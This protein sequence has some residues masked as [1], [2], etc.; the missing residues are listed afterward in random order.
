LWHSESGIQ[1]EVLDEIIAGFAREC[2]DVTVE[3]I[4]VPADEL[5]NRLAAAS[6]PALSGGSS[7]VGAAGRETPPDIFLAP[8]DLIE[9]LSAERLL[10]PVT[11]W[12]S[13]PTLIPLLPEAVDALRYA[14]ALYGLPYTVDT[15]ALYYNA[16]LVRDVDELTDSGTLSDLFSAASPETPFALDTRFEGAFWGV[17]AFGR[18]ALEENAATDETGALQLEQTGLADWLAWLQDVRQRQG[19]IMSDDPA[20]LQELFAAGNA[21]YLVAGPSALGPLRSELETDDDLS[22]TVN[23]TPLPAGPDGD[24]SPFLRVNAFLFSAA[25]DEEQTRLALQFAEFAAATESQTRIIREANLVP[26]N[27]LA[28]LRVSDPDVDSFLAQAKLS[29]PLPPR[30]ESQLLFQEG[31]ELYKSV[32][33][34]GRDPARAVDEFINYVAEAAQPAVIAYAGDD[35]LACAGGRLRFWY[36]WPFAPESVAHGALATILNGFA[37]HCPDVDVETAYAS[38]DELTAAL[39]AGEG[40]DLFLGPHYLTVP[41]ARNELIQPISPLVEQPVVDAYLPRS[42][43]AV[44]FQGE[45]YGLPQTM[46]VEALYYNTE[47]VSNPASTLDEL[48]TGVGPDRRAVLD[49]TFAGTYWGVSA[50]G[51]KLFDASGQL[52]TE[53]AA[54]VDWLTWLRSA[55]DHPGIVLSADQQTRWE[56][57]AN[58]EAAYLIAGPAAL[59]PLRQQ[60]NSKVRVIPLPAGPQG[61]AGPLLRVDAFLFNAAMER[62]QLELAL[63]LAGYIS[64]QANQSLLRREANLVPTNRSA[65]ETTEDA[66]ITTFIRQ[67]AETSVLLPGVHEMQMLA[68]G[69]RIYDQMLAGELDP[70]SAVDQM[71]DVVLLEEDVTNAVPAVAPMAISV[72][73]G[74]RAGSS[75]RMRGYRRGEC[76]ECIEYTPS[77]E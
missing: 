3:A 8:H 59:A 2:P 1:A 30:P 12:V 10:K 61:P 73:A 57:F 31:D 50:F 29:V 56:L 6:Q 42:I 71:L 5:P 76:E 54:Y 28:S 70:A 44:S 43:Q 15:M 9:P 26:A 20:K 45:L 13:T 49:S 35:V 34:D 14:D 37:E 52:I 36:S 46:D 19:V 68:S 63:A 24:A 48:L 55:R 4:F 65:A 41:L 21:A 74:G 58:G 38:P 23:V 53:Q 69:D 51:G 64:S 18:S 11:P 22:A 32:L 75:E 40:P 27:V 67:A 60:L 39:H 62:P 66:A 16:K 25:A 47:L 7:G 72:N 77:G 33:Q 17:L